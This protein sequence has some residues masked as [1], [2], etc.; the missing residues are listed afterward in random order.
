M[1]PQDLIRMARNTLRTQGEK[2]RKSILMLSDEDVNWR[3]NDDSNAIANLVL[4]IA[5]HLHQRVGSLIGGA[6]DRRDRDAEFEDR[7]PRTREE[8]VQILDDAVSE[9]DRVLAEMD[10]AQLDRQV[11]VRGRTQTLADIVFFAATH[12]SEHVG[13]IIYIAKLKLGAGFG[14]LSTPRRR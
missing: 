9:A 10:P 2:A 13:Q 1:E 8:L 6:P 7:R 14:T 12:T 11:E 4:H 3:P 5:G